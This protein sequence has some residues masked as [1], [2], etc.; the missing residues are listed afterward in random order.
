MG[1]KRNPKDW[2][3]AKR[4]RAYQLK[5]NRWKQ[6]DI[7]AALGVREWTVSRWLRRAREQGK[8]ALRSQ[9]RSG[10][11]R[12]L[13]DEQLRTIPEFLCHGAEAYGFLGDVWT[14]AR[15]AKVIEREFGIL[16]HKAH[17]S[18]ILKELEWTPQKPIIRASQRNEEEISRWRAERWR[19]IKK[20]E[21]GQKIP[22]FRG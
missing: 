5:K 11:P 15:I 17:V 8:E 7:A 4:L 21:E 3:E 13:T 19:E 2:N 22:N 18:R 6:R 9:S 10:A 16:Y 12:R 20:S 1:R 14:Y